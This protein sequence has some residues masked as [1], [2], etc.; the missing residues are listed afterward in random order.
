MKFKGL[1]YVEARKHLGLP[2]KN[3]YKQEQLEKDRECSSNSNSDMYEFATKI[4]ME[5]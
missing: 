2:V 1:N 3:D 4:V 5:L